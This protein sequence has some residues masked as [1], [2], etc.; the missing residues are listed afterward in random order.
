MPLPSHLKSPPNPPRLHANIAAFERLLAHNP[1]AKII[2]DHAGWDNT[3]YRTADLCRRL[4]KDYHI[5]LPSDPPSRTEP[6]LRM[7]HVALL[8][9]Y[10]DKQIHDVVAYLETLQ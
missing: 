5:E 10:T 7:A 1:R 4:L 9:E 3:G 6:E 2:W 8:D